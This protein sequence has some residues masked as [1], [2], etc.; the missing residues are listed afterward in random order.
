MTGPHHFGCQIHE[1]AAEGRGVTR[2]GQDVLQVVLFE[3]LDTNIR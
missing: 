3:G 1:F 2:Q